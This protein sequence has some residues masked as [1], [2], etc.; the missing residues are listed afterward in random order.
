[1]TSPCH[2]RRRGHTKPLYG[3]FCEEIKERK[4][5][6]RST[7]TTTRTATGTGTMTR[8]I[9][10]VQLYDGDDFCNYYYFCFYYS[11]CTVSSSSS[12]N[13]RFR[14]AVYVRT[15][16]SNSFSFEG[17]LQVQLQFK[18]F[19]VEFNLEFN[20]KF[21]PGVRRE[22]RCSNPG[23]EAPNSKFGV[24]KMYLCSFSGLIA[25]LKKSWRLE[26]MLRPKTRWTNRAA[27]KKTFWSRERT[28]KNPFAST[29]K[30]D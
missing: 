5:K 15:L 25:G 19:G 24:P 29:N 14:N 11:F 17:Q 18:K 2:K 1:M 3:G 8:N 26:N 30:K 27:E 4:D 16:G 20:S 9:R 23:F 28:L 13:P 6:E 12:P 7:T 10:Q 21:E 22:L